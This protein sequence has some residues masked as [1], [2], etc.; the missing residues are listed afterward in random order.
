MAYPT[1]GP[2]PATQ[3]RVLLEGFRRS[4]APADDWPRL[5]AIAWHRITWPHDRTERWGWWKALG[6]TED[7]W[8]AAWMRSY[9]ATGRAMGEMAEAA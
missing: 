4:G 3:M 7:E 2:N 9:S 6:S 1:Q 5:W 8:R